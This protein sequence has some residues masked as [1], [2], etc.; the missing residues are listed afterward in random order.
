MVCLGSKSFRRKAQ[1]H[2]NLSEN[3]E[4]F[5]HDAATRQYVTR[6]MKK[7]FGKK[8]ENTSL[9]KSQSHTAN[10]TRGKSDD[11]SIH[12]GR[13][14]NEKAFK[15]GKGNH[16]LS[17]DSIRLGNNKHTFKPSVLRY[18]FLI[19]LTS[20]YHAGFGVFMNIMH[21]YIYLGGG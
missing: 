9:P 18:G 21:I 20:L 1:G 5:N 8:K 17:N 7:D 2:Y 4:Y 11:S 15:H 14:P 19:I 6:R 16:G 12:D 13:N 3:C 10:Q